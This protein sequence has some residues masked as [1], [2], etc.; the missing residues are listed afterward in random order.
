MVKSIN[1][2]RIQSLLATVIC[3]CHIIEGTTTTVATAM[4]PMGEG[5]H[6]TLATAISGCADPQ[7]FDPA[8]GE[9]YATEKVMARANEKLWE[10]EGYR[11]A[12]DISAPVIGDH[13]DRMIAEHGELTS[14][15]AKLN[16]FVNGD[17]FKSLESGTRTL[18]KKQRDSM[19]DYADCLDS[20]LKKSGCIQFTG[21]NYPELVEYF[22]DG[23]LVGEQFVTPAGDSLMAGMWGRK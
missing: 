11:L 21:A 6:F 12:C 1:V 17:M 4:L 7:K 18:L 15:L 5:N 14:R 19:E 8:L 22:G 3:H 2:A 23:S 16:E 10:L 13:I 9:K 20:R